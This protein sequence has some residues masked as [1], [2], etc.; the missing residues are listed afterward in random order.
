MKP[1]S[2]SVTKF[3]EDYERNRE[4]SDPEAIGQQ[5]AETFMFA[6]PQGVQIVKKDDFLKALPQR[7]GFFKAV[8]LTLSKIKTLE[9][10]RL[11][12]HYLL[13]RADWVMQFDKNA[14]Q[15]ITEEISATYVLSQQEDRLKIVLQLDHQD[16]VKRVQ[17]L[18]LLPPKS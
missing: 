17:T 8:G 16:L 9:E 10:T 18:G 12:E 5:Y 11:D 3:F 2:H 15:L 1:V 7:Q 13:V 6:G 14:G 4:T